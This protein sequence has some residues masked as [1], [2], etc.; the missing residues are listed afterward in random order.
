MARASP[1]EAERPRDACPVS[2][3]GIG[4]AKS[5][6]TTGEGG[7]SKPRAGLNLDSHTSSTFRRPDALVVQKAFSEGLT[8]SKAAT[9]VGV[10]LAEARQLLRS[11]YSDNSYVPSDGENRP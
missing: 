6:T 4:R 1:D 11:S 9:L 7:V 8:L 10:T 3:V 5:G 2:G